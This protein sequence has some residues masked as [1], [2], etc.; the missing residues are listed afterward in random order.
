MSVLDRFIV[1]AA[2]AASSGGN[3]YNDGLLAALGARADRL[4]P[5]AAACA[6]RARESGF[7]WLDSLYLERFG[8]LRAL[9]P[10]G[11]LGLLV[12]Y[13]PG[14]V[15]HRGDLTRERAS[16]AEKNALEGADALLVTSNWMRGALRALVYRPQIAVVEP[17]RE[18]AP[19]PAAPPA[20]GVRAVLVANLV[21]GK[22]VEPFLRALARE[23]ADGDP[24]ALTILGADRDRDYAAA[25]RA[26]VASDG[27]LARCVSFAGEVEPA[28]VLEHLARSNLA[29]S[30]SYFEAYGMALAEARGA[31]VPIV[32]RAGGNTATL[33]APTSGGELCRDDGELAAA[34]LR[35]CRE[36][37]LL[38]ERVGRALRTRLPPRPWS[39]AAAE[40]SSQ[41]P[42]SA[43][44]P[45][46]RAATG[47]TNGIRERTTR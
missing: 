34:V 32:A 13:L 46:A 24:L 47:T 23:L 19:V 1:P 15:E 36:P 28:R 41:L 20:A 30:T 29:I 3:R 35:L 4:D 8:S 17:G 44:S 14:L 18:P 37:L 21:A 42:R 7:Y 45:R 10:R 22:G 38:S 16:D 40:F 9:A 43:A 6:L 12:H 5:E 33:V 31:G 27:R 11:S 2:G 39:Q 26:L 25:C